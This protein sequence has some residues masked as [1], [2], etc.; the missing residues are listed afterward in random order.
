MNTSPPKK[1]EGRLSVFF[2]LD[3]FAGETVSDGRA[4]D[5]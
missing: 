3:G 4:I 5:T 1:R 2:T